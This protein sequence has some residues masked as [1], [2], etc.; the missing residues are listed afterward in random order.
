MPKPRTFSTRWAVLWRSKNMLDGLTE[1]LMF[2]GCSPVM[3]F[4][5][6]A[7]RAWIAQ[8]YGYIRTRP[9][10]RREP[11]GW[12]MPQPIRVHIVEAR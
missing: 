1:H 7:A 11:H 8:E 2:H 6:R 9:D 10:L 4:T 12:R 3:F 5:R